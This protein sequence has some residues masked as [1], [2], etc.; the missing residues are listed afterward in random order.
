MQ[1][2]CPS[3]ETVFRLTEI[4]ASVASGM[5]QCGICNHYFNA[6]SSQIDVTGEDSQSY[7][8]KDVLTEKSRQLAASDLSTSLKNAYVAPRPAAPWW[9]TVLWTLLILA[10]LVAGL[11]QLAWFNREVLS[12]RDELQPYVLR[13]C[14]QLP[15]ELQKKVDLAQIELLSRDVRSHPTIRDALLITATFINH[16]EFEQPYPKVGL[17]LSN[18]TGEVIAQRYF[19]PDEYLQNDIQRNSLMGVDVPV[20]MIME[21]LDP[22]EETVSYRFEFL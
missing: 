5:V 4:Q 18:L 8:L 16:A 19:E 1:T 3:C 13:A 12:H 7:T 14:E 2:R 11:A 20:T 10:A 6:F 21:V 9:S 22:G 15:C 17:Q